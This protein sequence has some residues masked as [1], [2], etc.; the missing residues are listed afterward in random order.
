MPCVEGTQAEIACESHLNLHSGVGLGICKHFLLAGSV[1]VRLK[2]RAGLER[3]LQ[4][5]SA[6]MCSVQ[7]GSRAGNVSKP[8]HGEELVRI[9]TKHAQAA[10]SRDARKAS[11]CV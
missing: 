4:I 9:S 8:T 3:L 5:L 11:V 2:Q 1:L 7:D 10:Q 6:Y